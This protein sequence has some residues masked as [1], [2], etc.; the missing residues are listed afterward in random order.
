MIEFMFADLIVVILGISIGTMS[1]LL[2]GVGTSISLLISAPL[3]MQ[4]EVYH[5]FLFYMALLNTAQYSGTIPSIL[6][7]YPGESNSMP[8]VIEGAKFRKR[9]LSTLAIGLCAVG[10]LF[11]SVIA[12]ILTILVLPNILD[13]LKIFLQDNF[14]IILFGVALSAGL[15][16]FNNKKY[17]LNAILLL[18]GYLLSMVG[19]D[20]L[21][22]GY[23]YTFGIESLE[24]GIPFYPTIVAVMVAPILFKRI[25]SFSDTQGNEK[26]YSMS[27][28]FVL[29]YRNIKSSL[30]GAIVGFFCALTPGFGTLLSS[31]ASYALES[32]L[33]K[34]YPSK[35]LISAE[36]ANNSG[37]FSVLIPF[38]LLG[39]P[40][41]GS[42]FILYNYLVEAGW[43]PYQFENLESNSVMLMQN[44]IPWFLFVNLVGLIIAW[45]LAKNVVKILD[46]LKKYINLIITVICVSTTLYLGLVNYQ[47][48]YYTVCLICFSVIGICLKKINLTPILFTL[49]LG[50]E[51]EFLI[52]RYYTIWT[53]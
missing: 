14:K 7:N 15:F 45:P 30:R 20:S 29:F 19:I 26:L 38:I 32:K 17:I 37:G 2:P 49:I 43:S 41:T 35:K 24:N 1:G 3:L 8:A 23:R 28:V 34:N 5:L 51:L 36:T 10:S 11:G 52:T 53:H 33:Q 12:V 44:I 42:E 50:N 22:G 47:L 18:I 13:W 6:L 25:K 46:R 48:L 9:K 4:F 40:L 21:N 31:N 39:I 16:A 27:K